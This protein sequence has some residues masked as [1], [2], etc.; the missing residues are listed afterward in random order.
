MFIKFCNFLRNAVLL[1]L[2][3]YKFCDQKLQAAG[4]NEWFS[5]KNKT[6]FRHY[7]NY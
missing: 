7:L 2:I 6:T 4:V 3:F 1:L 5:I